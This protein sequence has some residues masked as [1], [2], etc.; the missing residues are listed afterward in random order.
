MELERVKAPKTVRYVKVVY[1]FFYLWLVILC[2]YIMFNPRARD[3]SRKVMKNDLHTQRVTTL[4]YSISQGFNIVFLGNWISIEKLIS[5]L[6]LLVT[7]PP[8]FQSL[9]L[10]FA[11]NFDEYRAW[12]LEVSL[13][14]VV[15]TVRSLQVQ[16]LM[17]AALNLAKGNSIIHVLYPSC[18]LIPSP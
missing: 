2:M 5:F 7:L 10:T 13:M 3:T 12:S 18:F 17:K 9:S 6:T 1:S 16:L 4:H 14:D 11:R 8:D 15:G